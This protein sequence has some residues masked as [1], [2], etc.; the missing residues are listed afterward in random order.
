[1]VAGHHHLAASQ[2]DHRLVGE[3]DFFHQ[4]L[5]LGIATA[6]VAEVMLGAGTHAATEV[7]LLK[8]LDEGHAHGGGEVGILA[9]RLL[10]TVETGCAAH[11][12]HR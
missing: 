6:A 5:L 1:M 2:A 9:I 4:L 7:A 11:I 12:D 3:E 10:Q 8:A